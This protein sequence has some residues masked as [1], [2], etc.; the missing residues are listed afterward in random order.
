[1]VSC[2]LANCY[3]LGSEVVWGGLT[4]PEGFVFHEFVQCFYF[5]FKSYTYPLPFVSSEHA[6]FHLPPTWFLGTMNNHSLLFS[7]HA[8]AFPLLLLLY[9]SIISF[10]PTVSFPATK[11]PS[12][13]SYLL[14]YPGSNLHGSSC[15]PLYIFVAL[16]FLWQVLLC[17]LG[18][19]W[20]QNILFKMWTHNRFIW[21]HNGALGY[22]V[23]YPLFFCAWHS[24][25]PKWL[26]VQP[27]FPVVLC[28]GGRSRGVWGWRRT[29]RR[30]IQDF[31]GLSPDPRLSQ[32]L[33]SNK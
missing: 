13:C 28:L 23:M 30:G 7:S 21:W 25:L 12:L 31:L 24:R 33:V 16:P 5:F 15:I 9:A 14:L 29:G 1:M 19:G 17:H 6:V 20:N 22:Y 10:S 2:L 27:S 32:K 3:F 8:L 18:W 26:L 4:I 11:F